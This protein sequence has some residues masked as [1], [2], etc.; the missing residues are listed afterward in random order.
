[1]A[2]NRTIEAWQ[3]L[4]VTKAEAKSILMEAKQ[5][6]DGLGVVFF[7]RQGTLLGAIRHKGFIPWDDDLDLGCV[8]GLHGFTEKSV[9][10]VAAAFR[11]NG[12]F[13]KVQHQ[14]QNIYVPMVK[15]STS[16]RIDWVC[17]RI[18]DS[19]TI[20]YPGVWIP[21]RVFTELKEIDFMGEKFLAPNPP[22]EYLRFKYGK[23]WK[24]PKQTGFEKDVVDLI[25]E[26]PV[27]GRAGRLKRFLTKYLLPWRSIRIRALD[28][29]GKPVAGA[30]VVVAGMDCSKTNSRGYAKLYLPYNDF[31]ALI[32]RFANHE[33]V[34][35]E[36]KLSQGETYVYRPDAQLTSG[37]YLVLTQE[38]HP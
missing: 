17:Y 22:E 14:Y 32:I 10:R 35:Y 8:I 7:I 33:E 16:V 25:L 21:V 27:L 9:D 23:D 13:V 6:L 34:L 20:H 38:S 24:I 4:D 5:I 26:G 1:M 19:S 3:P 18:T 37:R 28:L 12:Y 31:F 11:D 36:E 15:A 29:E 2:V 30:E